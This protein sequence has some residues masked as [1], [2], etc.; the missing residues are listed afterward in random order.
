MA[1]EQFIIGSALAVLAQ[2]I[3]NFGLNL[4]KL[5]HLEN[6]FYDPF[7]RQKPKPKTEI[8]AMHKHKKW[9]IGMSL[10]ILG[11]LG[12]F[13]ALIFAAQSVVAVL[14]SLT[15]VSNVF[16]APF[17]LKEKVSKTHYI[18]TLLIVTGCIIAVA[19]GPHDESSYTIS[20]L[21][22][23]YT[24][25]RFVIYAVIIAGII[26]G[27]LSLVG[28]IETKYRI[29]STNGH[30]ASAQYQYK[31]PSAICLKFHRVSFAFL[32]GVMGAQSVLL[33][34][35]FAEL[36][37]A[38]FKGDLMF[39]NVSTYLIVIG[40]GLTIFLQV[41]WLNFGLKR[42]GALYVVPVFQSI[43]TLT[44]IIG[45]LTIYNEISSL[46]GLTGFLFGCGILLTLIGVYHLSAKGTSSEIIEV[47]DDECE[48]HAHAHVRAV[49]VGVGV[50]VDN[51][52]ED[53]DEEPSEERV[54]NLHKMRRDKKRRRSSSESML[55]VSKLR[56]MRSR[57]H[58]SRKS[59]IVTAPDS[60]IDNIHSVA[61]GS[62]FATFSHQEHNKD[63]KPPSTTH[64]ISLE[65]EP[66]VV[67]PMTSTEESLK[68]EGLETEDS[69][70]NIL[71]PVNPEDR[72][73]AD[74]SSSAE[75][76]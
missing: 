30:E 44:S 23:L 17:L 60:E 20:E 18:S 70:P 74:N 64:Y 75:L 69:V 9:I 8:I 63:E 40:M 36:I 53:I 5:S 59:F 2:F 29:K 72:K 68:S 65:G 16:V 19:F 50:G 52:D 61:A 66:I 67:M 7:T 43:W 37:K 42:F 11:S 13:S 14:G 34:K 49:G 31:Y 62:I 41:R 32:G 73:K 35:S 55:P 33:G 54:I 22:A 6:Q 71:Q 51:D 26:V 57:F 1:A 47:N 24:T 48:K 45:G 38:S 21:V 56:D 39:A 58:S 4:Q 25:T 10:I 76:V 12:D 3:S 28:I 46:N 15:L 27:G